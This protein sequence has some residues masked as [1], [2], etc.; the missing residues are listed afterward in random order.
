LAGILTD[1][2]ADTLA[3]ILTGIL[4][5]ILADVLADVLAVFSTDTSCRY[6]LPVS[7]AS[8]LPVSFAGV[9]YRYIFAGFRFPISQAGESHYLSSFQWHRRILVKSTHKWYPAEQLKPQP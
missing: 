3:D 9:S 4:A 5:D 8:I 2:F 6:L 1:V 7:F